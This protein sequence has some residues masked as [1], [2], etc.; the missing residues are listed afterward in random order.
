MKKILILFLVFI[1]L[2]SCQGIFVWI[3]RDIVN[4]I[5]FGGLVLLFLIIGSVILCDKVKRLSTGVRKT[6]NSASI[7]EST[8]GYS[9]P[10]CGAICSNKTL[11][12]KT[13]VEF[14][15]YPDPHYSWDEIHTCQ[16]CET[17]YLLHNGT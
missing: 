5:G 3:V 4:L 9:C 12:S 13:E 17:I 7:I 16:K 6:D 15:E 8:T 1:L 10:N 2:T 14:D 11:K